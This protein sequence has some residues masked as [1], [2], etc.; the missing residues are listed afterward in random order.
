[1][2]GDEG[3]MI[4]CTLPDIRMDRGGFQEMAELGIGHGA[5]RTK[6]A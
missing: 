3:M 6:L 2:M 5:D 1:M 4:E